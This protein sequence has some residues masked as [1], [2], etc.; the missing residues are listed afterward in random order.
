MRALL[1]GKGGREHAIAAQLSASAEV[2]ELVAAPGNPGIAEVA[3]CVEIPDLSPATIADLAEHEGAALTV[4]GPEEPLVRGVVD[5]MR[6]RDLR[7]FGPVGAAARLEGSKSFAKEIMSRQGV[8]TA[9]SWTFDEPDEA[10]A[11]LRTMGGPWVV[12]ADGLAAGKGVTVTERRAEAER[13]VH[14]AI[15]EGRFGLAGRRV[16]IEEYLEGPELSLLVLTDGR[17]HVPL[18]PAQDFKRIG[19]GDEGPNTGGMGAYSPVPIAPPPLVDR[20]MDEIVEPTLV[21]VAREAGEPYRGV[22]YAGL[23]LTEEGPKVVEFNCRFGDPE[24]QAVL[25]RLVGD[26]GDLCGACVGGG[27]GQRQVSWLDRACVT[28]V[29]AA[30]GYP[31]EARTGQVIEGVDR[32]RELAG[33]A[34]FHAGTAIDEDLSLVVAGGRVLN[35]TA[36]GAELGEARQR[37]YEAVAEITFDGMQVR[38]DIAMEAARVE[39][40]MS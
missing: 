15:T 22:L 6:R 11:R 34:V 12:K 35:V 2:S 31:G 1:I 19:D 29:L 8:P 32:A 13:A 10:I 38:H 7:C 5:E 40:D 27:L 16:V 18:A 25:P 39:V 30:P 26:L 33:V 36:T 14:A 3:R 4:I 17:D 20:V 37:A 21:G 28:V 24:A 23:C 9:A